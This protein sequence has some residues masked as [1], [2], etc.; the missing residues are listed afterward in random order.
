[1][2]RLAVLQSDGIRHLLCHSDFLACAVYQ[3]EVALGKEDGEGNT[4]ETSACAEVK[5]F[6]TW[7]EVHH[8]GN[9]QR[10]EHV[11]L[12]EVVDILP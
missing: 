9:G 4:R 8:L 2:F 10:V 3:F 5:D 6:R 12:I 1:M 11:V 7:S